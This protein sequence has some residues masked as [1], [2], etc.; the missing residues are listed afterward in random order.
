[1]RLLDPVDYQIAAARVVEGVTRELAALISGCRVEH[2]GASAIPG[3]I[4]KGDVDVCVVVPPPGHSSAVLRLEAAGYVVKADTLR[5]PEL[6]MLLSPRTDVDLA[7]QVVAQGSRFEFFMRFRD[8][9]RG[10]QSLVDQYNAVKRRAAGLSHGQYRDAKA[11][12]IASVLQS[13]APAVIPTD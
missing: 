3:A 2:V 9:L 12:F 13:A 7:L 10:D 8:A 11:A 6:C 4:S 5:T 1:M